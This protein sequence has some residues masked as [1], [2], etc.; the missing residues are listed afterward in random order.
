MPNYGPDVE[1]ITIE[2][3]GV[4]IIKSTNI[5]YFLK[6][7]SKSTN[8][9]ARVLSFGKESIFNKIEES[10]EKDE[11]IMKEIRQKS[12]K[13]IEDDSDVSDVSDVSE[14]E[15]YEEK[16]EDIVRPKG[17]KIKGDEDEEEDEE[18]G[19]SSYDASIRGSDEEGSEG[20]DYYEEEQDE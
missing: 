13:K 19:L 18:E 11:D 10:L 1:Q 5:L 2:Y 7:L 4:S 16:K 17:P 6:S 12:K 3:S 8:S 20:S 9:M 14:R 15:S